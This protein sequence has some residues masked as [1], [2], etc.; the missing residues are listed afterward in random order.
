MGAWGDP[1]PG[2]PRLDSH[3]WLDATKDPEALDSIHIDGAINDPEALDLTPLYRETS[4]HVETLD[5]TP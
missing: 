3:T 2:G 1:R 5:L 4:D